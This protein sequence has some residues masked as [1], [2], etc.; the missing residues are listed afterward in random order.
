[1]L[2]RCEYNPYLSEQESTLEEN[3]Y[4]ELNGSQDLFSDHQLLNYSTIFQGVYANSWSPEYPLTPS[5]VNTAKDFSMSFRRRYGFHHRGHLPG[6]KTNQG[7]RMSLCVPPIEKDFLPNTSD[8]SE[9]LYHDHLGE[10]YETLITSKSRATPDKFY[11]VGQ[12]FS[13]IGSN[14]ISAMKDI[15]VLDE[16]KKG[17]KTVEA[18]L[19]NYR[20]F[21]EMIKGQGSPLME[22]CFLKPPPMY[23]NDILDR[24][25]PDS[26]VPYQIWGDMLSV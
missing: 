6:K 15:G 10:Y 24:L 13:S 4:K 3:V 20:V 26:R 14:L 8:W 12:T 16:G 23:Y 17:Y 18:N 21:K 11:F 22:F 2:L 1:M 9:W 25:Y 7:F 5:W 19:E